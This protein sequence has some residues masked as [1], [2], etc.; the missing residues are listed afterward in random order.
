VMMALVFAA[1]ATSLSRRA[2]G[3]LIPLEFFRAPAA[4]WGCN[5][6]LPPCQVEPLS[7]GLR[8][9]RS[10]LAISEVQIPGGS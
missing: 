8:W 7:G 10:I 4:D 5:G 2:A 3:W 1:A 9:H 6:G